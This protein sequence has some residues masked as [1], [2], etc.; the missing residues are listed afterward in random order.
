MNNLFKHFANYSIP[1]NKSL[2]V[3]GGGAGFWCVDCGASA[4]MCS[5]GVSKCKTISCPSGA[6]RR[7]GLECEGTGGGII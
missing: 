2:K 5:P 7:K 4:N 6:L 1:K 3:Q